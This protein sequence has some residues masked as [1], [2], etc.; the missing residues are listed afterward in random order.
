MLDEA[1]EKG[2]FAWAPQLKYWLKDQDH[3]FWLGAVR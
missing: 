3:I 1:E 2:I